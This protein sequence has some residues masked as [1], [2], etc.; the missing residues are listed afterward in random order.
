MDKVQEESSVHEESLS[1]DYEQD[2]KVFSNH[3]RHKS[4]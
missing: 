2:P 3:L 1:W 4:S